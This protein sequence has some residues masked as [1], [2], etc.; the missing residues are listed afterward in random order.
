V[1][2][3]T[4]PCLVQKQLAPCLSEKIRIMIPRGANIPAVI[5]NKNILLVDKKKPK[6][7]KV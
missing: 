6:T 5:K 4:F 2:K 3:E 1:I 7:D